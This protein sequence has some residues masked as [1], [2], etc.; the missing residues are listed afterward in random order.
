MA[1]LDAQW[2]KA[3]LQLA[4]AVQKA[5]LNG[6]LPECRCGRMVLENRMSGQVGGDF[7]FFRELN[8]DQV[9]LAI[10]DVVGHGVGPAL[11]MTMILGLLQGH[12]QDSRRPSRMVGY[13]NDQLVKL[14]GQVDHYI[15]CSLFYGVVDLPSGILLYVNAGHPEPIVCNRRQT[16]CHELPP[17]TMLL[18]VQ[19]GILPESCHQFAQH[20]R[21]VLYTDGIT[22]A[23]DEQDQPF[24]EDRFRDLIRQCGS[25]D[26][27]EL[28][29]RIF[30]VVDDFCGRRQPADDQTLV[31]IDFDM[32][33]QGT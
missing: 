26:P 20:D 4:A 21:V 2:E 19:Q 31:V 22:E 3:D 17:T 25:E 1:K 33:S 32:V 18:G 10:G 24:G 6:N 15:T 14:G 23:C 27:R 7:Y 29:R 9:A 13:V 12:P 28:T 8:Q 16:I 30:Q 11:I 5:L